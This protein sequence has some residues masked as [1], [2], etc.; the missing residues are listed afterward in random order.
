MWKVQFQH[1]RA[2]FESTLKRFIFHF[3]E[4]IFTKLINCMEF[5]KLFHYVKLLHIVNRNMLLKGLKVRLFSNCC[6]FYSRAASTVVRKR[7]SSPNGI[8]NTQKQIKTIIELECNASNQ[9][10]MS[11]WSEMIF[12]LSLIGEWLSGKLD[13]IFLRTSFNAKSNWKLGKLSGKLSIIVF[14]K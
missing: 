9:I 11:I 14:N 2:D 12:E 4:T 7:P 1:Q 6:G 3:L 5:W 8:C 13:L 10:S